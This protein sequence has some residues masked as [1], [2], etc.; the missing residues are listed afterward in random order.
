MIS[1]AVDAMGGDNAPAAL[2]A[3]ALEA[4]KT[5]GY[6]IVLVGR[7]DLVEPCLEG[8]DSV[9]GL[10]SIEDASQVIQ[11]H[12]P[13]ISSVRQKRDSSIS[14]GINLLKSEKVNAFVSAGNTGAVVAAATLYLRTLEGVER[15]GI[16]VVFPT[17][18]RPTV[19]IDAGANIDPKPTQMLQYGLMGEV[20]ARNVLARENPRVGLLNIGEEET[21]G[22]E[23][24]KQTFSLLK[25]SGLNFVGN[26]EGR[27]VFLGEVDVI[28]CDGFV[29]N[30]VLKVS[31]SL[32]EAIVELLR[33]ELVR[34]FRTRVGAA[35]ARPALVELKKRM[36]YSEYG[37]ALLLGVNGICV[38][39]HG[40]SSPKAVKNAIRVAGESVKHQ[41]GTLVKKSVVHD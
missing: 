38:I 14:V 22:T 25:Q 19:V 27:D 29:G 21:K 31:E 4:A 20:Y 37:G 8:C 36:D 6:K 23:F 39:A 40:G 16:A 13:A 7:R 24:M 9:K 41:L 33:K 26:V 15:P 2:V 12:E 18:S 34:N 1:I 17:V 35:L 5:L 11:M 10:V 32:G 30:V 28:V 3:G